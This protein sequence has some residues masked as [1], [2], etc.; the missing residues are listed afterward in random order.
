MINIEN[1]TIENQSVQTSTSTEPPRNELIMTEGYEPIVGLVTLATLMGTA[2]VL[3]L[4]YRA[5]KPK[6]IIKD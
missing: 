1:L 2:Y 6:K 3:N 4:G 5:F